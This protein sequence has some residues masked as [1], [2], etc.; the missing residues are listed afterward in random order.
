MGLFTWERKIP[1]MTK[2]EHRAAVIA[3]QILRGIRGLEQFIDDPTMVLD[4]LRLQSHH[5]IA[6]V[7]ET[8]AAFC[9]HYEDTGG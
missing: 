1:D 6:G 4:E 7:Q 8:V 9:A 3:K 5:D 2:A